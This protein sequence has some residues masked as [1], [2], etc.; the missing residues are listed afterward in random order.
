MKFVIILLS[1]I[2]IS[3]KNDKIVA[4][5]KFTV[6]PDTEY[7]RVNGATGLTFDS[8]NQEFVIAKYDFHYFSKLWFYKYN[9][10]NLKAYKTDSKVLPIPDR[11]I[12]VSKFIYHIQGI[13]Y[14]HETDSFWII[15]S[16]EKESNDEE[17]KLINID[18][19]GN[20]T[21]EIL[22]DNLKFQAGMLAINKNI[23]LIKPNNKYELFFFDL[24]TEKVVRTEKTFT[25]NEGLAY[26]KYLDEVWIGSDKGKIAVYDYSTFKVKNSYNF[27]TLKND[28]GLQNIEGML[29]Y[30]PNKEVYIAFDAFLHG[31]N[32]NGNCLWKFSY[33]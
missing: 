7:G 32:R 21:K 29:V 11:I 8:K 15:G 1:V 27:E 22:L 9:S 23:L 14:S 28:N 6:I 17:R 20:L 25:L 5:K 4:V 18:Q 30:S 31:N 26:D 19:K 10:K 24:T 3:C 13:A 12:D 16:E 2:L 33:K